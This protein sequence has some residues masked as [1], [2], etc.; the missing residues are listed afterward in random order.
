MKDHTAAQTPEDLLEDLRDLLAQAEALAGDSLKSHS[1]EA[2]GTLRE[3]FD[4]VRERIS[5]FGTEARR[6]VVDGAHRADEQIREHPY[7]ALITAAVV[8]LV[9]GL[10]LGRHSGK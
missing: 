9:A 8:G 7:Q 3:R 4:A 1:P 2:L 5:R 6:R 10:L